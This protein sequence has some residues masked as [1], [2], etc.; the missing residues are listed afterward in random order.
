MRGR[1]RRPARFAGALV[2]GILWSAAGIVLPLAWVAAAHGEETPSV[3]P[4]KRKAYDQAFKA[5][6]ADP[7]NLDKTFAFAG[8]AIDV[9]DFDGAISALERML[10]IDPN[11]PR[12]KL[13]LGVVA[14]NYLNDALASPNVPPE[15][16]EKAERFLAEIDKRLSRNRFSGSLY[17]GMRYQSNAN[18]GPAT[19][20]VRVFG[21][22]ATLSDQFTS[23]SD[24]NGFAAAQVKHEFDFQNQRGDTMEST[25]LLY[26]TRQIEQTQVNLGYAELTAGPRFRFPTD[27]IGTVSVRPYGL[28]DF[29]ALDDVRYY[30]APG[31]GGNVNAIISPET[32]ADIVF[33]YRSLR[34][35]DTHKQP[36]NTDRNG[37]ELR[38]Q[39]GATQVL[40]DFVQVGGYFGVI[41]QDAKLSSQANREY[42][43][44]I[45]LGFV[46]RP[47]LVP[48]DLPWNTTIQAT[49]AWIDYREPD[50][51]VDPNET[52]RDRD[53]RLS[54][55][56]SVPIT[57][58]FGV[59]VTAARFMRGS[60][61]PNFAY[62]NTSVAVG[63]TFRF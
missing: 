61:I 54:L 6:M 15:V 24:F 50:P 1:D 40:F 46:Y 49:R 28:V 56:T 16:T 48:G 36:F 52:R 42:D 35:R 5:M 13:E 47:P 43:G 41:D 21:V 31:G 29:V 2:A 12:V 7:G 55:S 3:D 27:G 32:T 37:R 60:S 26:G 8:L 59:N 63:A 39:V 19:T 57:D 4:E 25:V 11:L 14:Q 33:E 53:W 62:T 30:W 9:G 34:Y 58:Q 23:K 22:D 17:A 20:N 18:A 10:L 51:I 45:T 38:G 44:T